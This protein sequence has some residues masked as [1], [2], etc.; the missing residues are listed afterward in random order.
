[1]AKAGWNWLW[2]AKKWHYFK[3]DGR[4]LCGRWATFG[5][6]ADAEGYKESSDNCAG[7]VRRY[8][9][10]FP[11]VAPVQADTGDNRLPVS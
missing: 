2:N 6:N 7:C 8:R 9:D 5:S 4:S 1:M 3:E 10:I 11:D